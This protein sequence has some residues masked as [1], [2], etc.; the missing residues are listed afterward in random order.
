MEESHSPSFSIYLIIQIGVEVSH[1][2]GWNGAHLPNPHRGEVETLS[3][4]LTDC[5]TSLKWI[6]DSVERTELQNSM[7]LKIFLEFGYLIKY[8][9]LHLLNSYLFITSGPARK[10]LDT[11]DL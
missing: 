4:F 8:P 7:L 11:P 6:D 9:D 1:P 2:F 5:K 3:G 10:T